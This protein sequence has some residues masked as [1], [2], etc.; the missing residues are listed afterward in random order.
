MEDNQHLEGL[1]FG[2]AYLG[3]L[4]HFLHLLLDKLF[5]GKK[6][7]TTVAKKVLLEQL[8]TSPCNNLLFMV[9]YG[10]VIE[11]KHTSETSLFN[12]LRE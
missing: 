10:L 9:Y 7:K 1:I 3:P 8:T 11:G 6:D 5:K 12:L 2:F 4:G